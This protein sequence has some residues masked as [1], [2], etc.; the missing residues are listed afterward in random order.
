MDLPGLL[1][2]AGT[3]AS[4]LVSLLLSIHFSRESSHHFVVK[5]LAKAQQWTFLHYP[6]RT[7][8]REW[9]APHWYASDQKSAN[10]AIAH[11]QAMR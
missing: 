11:F 2:L 5:F 6:R 3:V 7:A 1:P 4:L 10:V 8:L 9:I